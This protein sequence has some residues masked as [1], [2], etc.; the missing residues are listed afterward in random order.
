MNGE[1]TKGTRLKYTLNADSSENETGQKT[2]I[3][4]LSCSVTPSG[5]KPE[6]Y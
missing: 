6:T 1:M 5:F 3:S 2:G 4:A